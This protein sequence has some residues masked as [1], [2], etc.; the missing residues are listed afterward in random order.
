M[1]ERQSPPSRKL[2]MTVS[3]S[4]MLPNITARW[5]IDLSPGTVQAPVN[6]APGATVI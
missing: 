1:V 2:R 3:P 5:L 4:A 6:P